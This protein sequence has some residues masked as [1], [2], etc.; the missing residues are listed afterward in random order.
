[1]SQ[2]SSQE[3]ALILA[4]GVTPSVDL[5]KLLELLVEIFPTP[6]VHRMKSDA[7]PSISF[8]GSRISLNTYSVLQRFIVNP[9]M[10]EA[11]S[12]EKGGFL[13]DLED[14]PP[15]NLTVRMGGR[16]F[17]DNI[18]KI[19]DETNKLK[20]LISEEIDRTEVDLS[21][22]VTLDSKSTFQRLFQETS[23]SDFTKPSPVKITRM[24]FSEEG[25]PLAKLFSAVEEVQAEN[26][27]SKLSEGI[28]AVQSEADEEF[29]DIEKEKLVQTLHQDNERQDSQI[30]RF[31]QFLK[32]EVL[33]RVRLEVSFSIMGS[34]AEKLKGAKGIDKDFREYVSKTIQLSRWYGPAS[35]EDTLHFNLSWQ[36]GAQADFSVG[37]ELVKSL[38]YRCLPVWSEASAQLF[39]NESREGSLLREISYRFRTNGRDPR[40]EKLSAFAS[41]IAKIEEELLEEKPEGYTPHRLRRMLMEIWFLYLVV[42][43]DVLLENLRSS[44]K[45]LIEEINRGGKSKIEDLLRKLKGFDQRIN[46]FRNVLSRLLKRDMSGVLLNIKRNVENLYIVVQKGIVNSAEIERKG[47]KPKNPLVD[48]D[49]GMAKNSGWFN[50]IRITKKLNE[51]HDSLFSICVITTMK[52]RKLVAYSEEDTLQ[53]TRIFSGPM[54]NVIWRPYFANDKKRTPNLDFIL[55]GVGAGIDITYDPDQLKWKR[56]IKNR[57][58]L[59]RRHYRAA[60]VVAFTTLVYVFLQ[61]LLEKIAKTQKTQISSWM[62]RVQTKGKIKPDEEKPE[63]YA[64]GGDPAIYAAAHTVEL[65]LMRDIPI[66]MQGLVEKEA[67]SKGAFSNGKEGTE[68][69]RK[70]AILAL[71][72]SLPIF[73][74]S[75]STPKIDKVA[76]LIYSIRPSDTRPTLEINSKVLPISAKYFLFQVRT[77]LANAISSPTTNLS[78]SQKTGYQISFDKMHSRVVEN[79]EGFENSQLIIEEVGRLHGFG[80]DQILLVF[81][82]F[83]NRRIHR[84]AQRNSLDAQIFS[85]DEV[86]TKFPSTYVY[87]LKRDVYPVF[88]IR[89]REKT[90]SAF[91]VVNLKD[92][93]QFQISSDRSAKELLPVFTFATLSAVEDDRGPQ[94]GFC[95]YFLQTDSNLK[96]LDWRERIRSHLLGEESSVRESLISV[97]R[98]LHFLEAEKQASR[99]SFTPTLDPFSWVQPV[100]AGKAGEI[101]VIPSGKKQGNV[102]ISLP[103]LLSRVSDSL[104]RSRS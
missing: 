34:L 85:L 84:S 9:E 73:I 7:W 5:P 71:S 1:M 23:A 33:S 91:E 13:R 28:I 37:D 43:P 50:H 59:E 41:K 98:G 17:E 44:A 18:A 89:T 6:D 104:H 45:D 21:A 88:R 94:S 63:E 75:P 62:L 64:N 20:Q 52:E 72:K 66:R 40:S 67:S 57:P 80:Y 39:E 2:I 42:S 48:A 14:L 61:V 25:V 22:L 101:E 102:L 53:A 11:F 27:L 3:G 69:Q 35:I 74:S 93:N 30:T 95:T 100:N 31:F 29:D 92:H 99:N 103:S 24:G 96:N 58:E 60:S 87:M 83:G 77:Y 56:E 19:S 36:Y 68:Y 54:T 49:S 32:D 15:K 78:T 38:F 46:S 10:H 86:S 65:A 51:A 4:R 97:L 70:G 12:L 47:S 76:L 79:R 81:D 8:D 16:I 55:K 82:Y 26:W 90:E